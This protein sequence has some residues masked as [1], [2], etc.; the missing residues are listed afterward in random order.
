MSKDALGDRMKMLENI[1]CDRNFLPMLPIVA[2]VDGRSFHSFTKGLDR[3]FDESFK[4]CILDTMLYL[5]KETNPLIVYSQSDEIS[6]LWYSSNIDSQV[7][8]NGRITKMVSQLAAQT[9]LAFYRAV[10]ERMPKKY[11]EKLPTFDARVWQVPTKE[12]AV[13]VFIWRELDASKNSITMAARSVY[14]DKELFKKN[15]ADK[16]EMLYKKGINWNDYPAYF[17]RGTYIQKRTMEKVFLPSEIEK[18]P[19]NHAARKNPDLIFKRAEYREVE[20][21][22]ITTITNRVD[23]FFNGEDPKVKSV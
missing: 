22:P 7:W 4:A 8:F 5:A 11:A 6:L 23:V 1:E 13:N 10:C 18:L 9:T 2:R 17:K 21:P 20:L 19:V 3:P 16:H 14:S 12:E 15:S